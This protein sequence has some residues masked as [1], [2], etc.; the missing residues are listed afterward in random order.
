MA[1]KTNTYYVY[2]YFDPD[3]IPF[4]VGKGKE[5]RYHLSCHLDE[6]NPNNFLKNKICKVGAD[7]I[8]IKFPHKDLTEEQAFYLEE[9]YIAG[10]G[11]RDLGLGPLCNLTNGGE[12]E[13]GRV[14]SKETRQKISKMHKGKKIAPEV[15]ERQAASLR[16][17]YETRPNPFKDK[18]HTEETRK[19]MSESA[20][21]RKLSNEAKQK[22]SDFNKGRLVG[23]KNPMYG[24]SHTEEAKRKIGEASTGRKLSNETKRKIGDAHKGNIPWNKGKKWSTGKPAW[25]KG[26]KMTDAQKKKISESAEGKEGFLGEQNPGAKLTEQDVKIIRQSHKNKTMTNAEICTKFDISQSALGHIVA[27]RTWKYVK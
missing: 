12:G 9:Y 19:Q 26:K 1:N 18:K 24:K 25:N 13:S 21:G 5:Y 4:Y 17:H 22:L 23:E 8:D 16:K 6:S 27:R 15:V 3:N 20:I 11:R 2:V 7:N 14:V 10:Y